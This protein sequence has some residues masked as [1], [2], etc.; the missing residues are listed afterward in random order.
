MNKEQILS[1]L[2]T[3]LK[4][5]GAVLV[6]KGLTSDAGLESIVGGI[7]TIVG[8]IWSMRTHADDKSSSGGGAAAMI[9]LTGLLAIG[10]VSGLTGC[11]TLDA[12]GP[13]KGDKA[14]YVADT[15]LVTAYDVLDRFVTF[16]YQHRAALAGQPSIQQS[17][18]NIRINAPRWFRDAIIARD[19]YAVHPIPSNHTAL[20]NS[21]RII[22]S[23]IQTASGYLIANSQTAK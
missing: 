23:A 10:C 11:A 1:I 13:Y 21:V 5:A 20:Q 12:S 19:A 22:Q 6:T 2:R 18:D 7:I 3:V 9:I 4:T 8:I 17:A 15:T 16:E 14:L